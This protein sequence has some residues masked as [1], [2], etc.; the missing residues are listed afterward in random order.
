MTTEVMECRRAYVAANGDYGP[1]EFT[2]DWTYLG[3]AM[4]VKIKYMIVDLGGAAKEPD[5]QILQ[6]TMKQGKHGQEVNAGKMDR[7]ILSDADVLAKFT[8]HV[9]NEAKKITG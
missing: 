5:I 2:T 1:Y 6:T 4:Q 9:E 8:A 3:A 7:I